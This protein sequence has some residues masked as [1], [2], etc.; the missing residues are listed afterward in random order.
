MRKYWFKKSHN[1]KQNSVRSMVE[2]LETQ[3]QLKYLTTFNS[4]VEE[5]KEA[6]FRSLGDIFG[7]S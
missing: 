4:S 5:P 3:T 6:S 2:P 1:T 7:S